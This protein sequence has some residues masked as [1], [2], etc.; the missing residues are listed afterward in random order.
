[1]ARK[2]NARTTVLDLAESGR[3]FG[4]V[5]E[6][7]ARGRLFL[8]R[9]SGS[10]RR[11]DTNLGVSD[12]DYALTTLHAMHPELRVVRGTREYRRLWSDASA[13]RAKR[14]PGTSLQGATLFVNPSKWIQEVNE[15]MTEDDTHGA[16]TRQAER[17]GMSV[18]DFARKVMSAPEGKYTKKTRKRA[19]LALTFEKMAKRKKRSN[20]DARGGDDDIYAIAQTMHDEWKAGKRSRPGKGMKGSLAGWWIFPVTRAD[21]R[22]WPRLKGQG[23]VMLSDHTPWLGAF[24][25]SDRSWPVKN[26][27]PAA[28]RTSA[29]RQQALFV[30]T[31]SEYHRGARDAHLGVKKANG[32]KRRNGAA[33]TYM[34]TLSRDVSERRRAA[35]DLPGEKYFHGL[36]RS[37]F[38]DPVLARTA[39]LT[40]ITDKGD[41]VVANFLVTVSSRPIP[42]AMGRGVKVA[43][44]AV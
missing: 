34:I 2:G 20:P 36:L 22:R 25:E 29:A 3:D 28:H 6:R 10:P 17:A 19:S 8:R 38:R 15:E 31:G 27:P 33:E 44:H 39:A 37:V 43:V 7:D 11:F 16:F 40:R 24:S 42:G 18:H 35:G 21:Q 32:R 41:R 1:M 14:N 4:Y 23:A 9:W 12:V 13:K 30:E 5:M 26:P